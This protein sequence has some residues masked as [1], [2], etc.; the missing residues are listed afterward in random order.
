MVV[1]N[2]EQ[3]ASGRCQ[4]TREDVERQGGKKGRL[5]VKWKK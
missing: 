5:T 2:P 3:V 4:E 1:E